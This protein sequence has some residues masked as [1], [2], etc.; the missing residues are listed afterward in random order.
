MPTITLESMK[1]RWSI[2]QA[3]S[4]KLFIVP[5]NTTFLQQEAK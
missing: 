3:Q 1:L 4:A 2:Q 5:Q